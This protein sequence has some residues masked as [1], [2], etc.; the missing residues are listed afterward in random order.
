MDKQFCH[1]LDFSIA[2]GAALAFLPHFDGAFVATAQVKAIVV[3][4]NAIFRVGHA[5]TTQSQIAFV[6]V[7]VLVEINAFSTYQWLRLGRWMFPITLA[8]RVNSFQD[9]FVVGLFVDMR[10]ESF[11]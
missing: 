5:E 8:K 3:H 2:N 10:S 6:L 1:I 4:E 7:Q 11:R 9:C